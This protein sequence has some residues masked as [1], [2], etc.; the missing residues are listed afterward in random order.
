MGKLT[1]LV[2]ISSTPMP[3]YGFVSEGVS[4]YGDER[5]VNQEII[6]LNCKYS[7][8]AVTNQGLLFIKWHN[9]TSWK[10]VELPSTFT[11]PSNYENVNLRISQ[12]VIGVSLTE[13]SNIEETF[14]LLTD[15]GFVLSFG[16]CNSGLRGDSTSATDS[17]SS[18]S[19]YTF[20]TLSNISSIGV[21]PGIGYA[22]N[23]TGQLHVWGNNQ[24]G[25]LGDPDPNLILST[26]KHLEFNCFMKKLSFGESFCLYLCQDGRVF[27]NGQDAEGEISAAPGSIIYTPV[28]I[29]SSLSATF[30]SDMI[31]DI[32][33]SEKTS[34]AL[35][36][37][38]K[39]ATWGDDSQLAFG[40]E[41]NG[42]YT[43]PATFSSLNIVKAFFVYNIGIAITN[44][45]ETYYWGS[46]SAGEACLGD[47]WFAAKPTVIPTLSDV[48]QTHVNEIYLRAACG[49]MLSTD[50][51]TS[52]N[53]TY[54]GK[55]SSGLDGQYVDP[56]VAVSATT[57]DNSLFNNE[58]LKKFALFR[59][60]AVVNSISGNSYGWGEGRDYQL[61]DDSSHPVPLALS[62]NVTD[63]FSSNQFT[64]LVKND[65]GVYGLGTVSSSGAFGSSVQMLTTLTKLDTDYVTSDGSSVIQVK[66][67]EG[68]SY[69]LT[70]SGKVYGAGS[71]ANQLII[72]NS[73]TKFENFVRISGDDLPD[74]HRI[75]KIIV[76]PNSPL[77]FI[78]YEGDAYYVYQG[79]HKFQLPNS[80]DSFVIHASSN[81][82]NFYVITKKGNVYAMGT[83]N[84]FMEISQN[85][86]VSSLNNMTLYA[87]KES[88]GGVPYF[89][90][91]ETNLAIL[92]ISNGWTC[93]GTASTSDSVCNGHGA[94]VDQDVCA[95]KENYDGSYCEK[96]TCGGISNEDTTTVCSGTGSC[97]SF[98]TCVCKQG[99][100]GANCEIPSCFGVASSNTGIVCSGRG[101]CMGLD[102][103]SC[104]TGYFGSKCEYKACYFESIS[105][106]TGAI[107]SIKNKLCRDINKYL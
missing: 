36:S 7:C 62:V 55:C 49:M 76:F 79:I 34:L 83:T 3:S 12:A 57:F 60:T 66:A 92:A 41:G 27:G 43:I 29:T 50:G 65:G 69:L 102:K 47:L 86:M 2:P 5:L 45:N 61:G 85:P 70:S 40:R 39:I 4:N 105:A 103:C 84:E 99:Y 74:N 10:L 106:G 93:N 51:I 14:L 13:G 67:L 81:Y 6:S 42:G 28:E 96:F 97:T 71:N 68:I 9:E 11:N 52:S 15:S 20:T 59:G 72:N 22:I 91:P 18:N 25:I 26:P 63:I 48:S 32:S 33:T 53:I 101:Q 35:T 90:S 104:M 19:F 8:I 54:W 73:T 24:N 16:Y 31:I 89:I 58:I 82:L 17:L 94:C 78:T 100:S 46:N 80:N 75:R 64:I 38:G 87:T 77:I 21:G 44:T 88:L 56:T 1:P 95:C 30:N 107:L 37:T 23:S 98:D